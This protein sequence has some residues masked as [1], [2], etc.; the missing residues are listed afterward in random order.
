MGA[1]VKNQLRPFLGGLLTA[2]LTAVY[3]SMTPEGLTMSL[4]QVGMMVLF[5]AVGYTLTVLN[6]YSGRHEARF[7]P[8]R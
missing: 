3:A 8:K 4:R 5:A 7:Q 2:V 1:F 6:R